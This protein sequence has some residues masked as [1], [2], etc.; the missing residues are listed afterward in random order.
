MTLNI[1]DLFNKHSEE[2]IAQRVAVETCGLKQAIFHLEEKKTALVKLLNKEKE[3]CEKLKMRNYYLKRALDDNEIQLVF[4]GDTLVHVDSTLRKRIE[5]LEK[6]NE[7]LKE[8]C[9]NYKTLIRGAM[10]RG[11]TL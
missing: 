8:R 7:K 4:H 6:E 5:E 9:E 3:A 10:G 1:L 2:R 11:N